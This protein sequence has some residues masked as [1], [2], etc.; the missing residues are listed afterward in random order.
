MVKSVQT[1][2]DDDDVSLGSVEGA[3]LEESVTAGAESS[4]GVLG[5]SGDS[6]TFPTISLTLSNASRGALNASLRHLTY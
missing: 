1:N 2:D 5:N 4:W 6:T 3:L